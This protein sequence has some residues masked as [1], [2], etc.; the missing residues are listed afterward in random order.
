M[1]ASAWGP[2]LSALAGG[3]AEL[4]QAIRDGEVEE[5]EDDDGTKFYVFDDIIIGE[6]KSKKHSQ[7]VKG[8]KAHIWRQAPD[9]AVRISVSVRHSVVR[10]CCSAAGYFARGMQGFV[11]CP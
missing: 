6:R 4:K 8:E 9:H 7:G 5:T 2:A 1:R 10:K 11:R 3:E